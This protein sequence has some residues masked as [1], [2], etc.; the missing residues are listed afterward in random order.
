MLT[1]DSFNIKWIIS[2]TF[3]HC[4]VQLFDNFNNLFFNLYLKEIANYLNAE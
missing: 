3:L 2:Q 4:S 1:I